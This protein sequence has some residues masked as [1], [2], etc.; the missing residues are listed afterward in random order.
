MSSAATA[1]P[2]EAALS[3]GDGQGLAGADH[4]HFAA[5][6][7]RPSRSGAAGATLNRGTIWLVMYDRSV[8]VP[9]DR[10]EN[11]GRTITYSNVVRKLRPIAMWKGEAMTVDLPKSEMDQAKVARCAVLLQAENPGGLPGPIL[12]AASIYYE[13]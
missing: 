5:A 8:T 7:R 12:G 9:I 10:G 1:P 3:R 2:V 11:T 6:T 4:A 13:R